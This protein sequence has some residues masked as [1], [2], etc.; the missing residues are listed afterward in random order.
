[1]TFPLEVLTNSVLA[2]KRRCEELFR[3]STLERLEKPTTRPARPVG[4]AFHKGIELR[5]PQAG[6]DHLRAAAGDVLWLESERYVS[7]VRTLAYDA[8]LD[9]YGPIVAVNAP[10]HHISDLVGALAADAPEGVALG[11]WRS[12]GGGYSFSLR[13][14]GDGPDVSEIAAKFG[15]GGHRGAAGFRLDALPEGLR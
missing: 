7:D 3:L 14:R 13:S 12:A 8:N 6:S 11:W 1:M 9:G 4:S 5:S 2:K 10:F 15:G